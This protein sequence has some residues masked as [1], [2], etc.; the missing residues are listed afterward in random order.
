MILNQ[1]RC[2]AINGV[3]SLKTK[4]SC[5]SRLFKNSFW[6]T[7]FSVIHK[8]HNLSSFYF[9]FRFRCRFR[10]QSGR[11]QCSCKCWNCYCHGCNSVS[12]ALVFH[13]LVVVLSR[14]IFHLFCF[15]YP[16]QQYFTTFKHLLFF[17]GQRE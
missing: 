13:Y 1:S 4:K 17:L 5:T 2:G 9:C 7:N 3:S 12:C 16:I 10:S 6:S 14:F 15:T 8:F 11:G